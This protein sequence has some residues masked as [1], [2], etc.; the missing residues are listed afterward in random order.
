MSKELYTYSMIRTL[1]DEGEDYIDSF[2]PFVLAVMPTN[3]SRVDLETIQRSVT[4]Q[5]GLNIPRHSLTVI[6]N[7]A[8]RKGYL[9]QS[10]KT[11]VL[12][13]AGRSYISRFE[14]QRETDRRLNHLF[15]NA[16]EFLNKRFKREYTVDEVERIIDIFIR[17]NLSLFEQF[18][19]FE[20]APAPLTSAERATL[21]DYEGALFDYFLEIE[22]S[23]PIIY[24]TMYDIVCGSIISS[25]IYGERIEEVTKRFAATT[26]FLDSNF[27]FNVLGLHFDEVNRPAQELFTLMKAE[28]SFNFR[29]FDVTIQEMVRVLRNYPKHSD[30]YV[31]DIKVRSIYSSLKMKGWTKSTVDEFIAS[32][33]KTLINHGISIEKTGVIITKHNDIPDQQ[34]VLIERHKPFQYLYG[35]IHDLFV[36]DYIKRFRGRDFRRIEEANVIFLTSDLRL[37]RYNFHECGHK[38]NATVSEVISDRLLTNLLWLKNPQVLNKI[39]LRSIVSLH[40]HHLFIERKIWDKFIKMVKKLRNDGTISEQDVANLL[41]NQRIQ[42]LLMHFEREEIDSINESWVIGNIKQ[43]KE[44]IDQQKETEQAN[45]KAALDEELEKTKREKEQEL[46]QILEAFQQKHNEERDRDLQTVRTEE[47][48][49]RAEAIKLI[50]ERLRTKA[51]RKAR[52]WYFTY[53]ALIITI[54]FII[55]LYS[56]P[57]I[58][59]NWNKIEPAAWVL[60]AVVSVIFGLLGI[61]LDIRQSCE[62]KL[63]DRFYEQALQRSSVIDLESTLLQNK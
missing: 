33:D 58:T 43:V 39:S 23:N 61:K 21:K 41:Y 37:A 6:I 15:R 10:N 3:R 48:Q 2:W 59:G 42:D 38:D 5:Y 55:M 11:Y 52:I 34:R 19:D 22:Q 56:F 32:I 7:R 17:E 12:S 26:V 20:K 28:G 31:P 14:T 1:Y 16:Q 46:Q 49:G 44:E 4:S 60:G 27:L 9:S 45:Q 47:Y 35:Q 13:D 53:V 50:K 25:I 57:L 30:I 18:L 36:I 40:S 54:I 62:K 29:V 63:C 8:K 24:Q 51:Q